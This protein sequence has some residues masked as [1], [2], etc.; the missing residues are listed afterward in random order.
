MV[1]FPTIPRHRDVSPVAA[2]D[3]VHSFRADSGLEITRARF[4]RPLLSFA[5]SYLVDYQGYLQMRD[6]FM[7][8]TRG[9]A[10]TFDWTFPHGHTIVTESTGTPIAITVAASHGLITGNQVVITGASASANGTHTVTHVD[11]DTVTLDG[12][13]AGPGGTT[14]QMAPFYPKMRFR[15]TAFPAAT[16]FAP[17]PLKDRGERTI[18]GTGLWTFSIVID[19]AF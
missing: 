3:P 13:G 9:R 15:D 6:F 10:L 1:S 12:T 19:E 5:L 17:G 16:R 18:G 4:S 11:G 8:E 14:G 7:R 2:S